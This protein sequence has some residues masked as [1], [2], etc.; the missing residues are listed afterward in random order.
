MKR[1]TNLFAYVG[2]LLLAACLVSAIVIPHAAPASTVPCVPVGSSANVHV[3]QSPIIQG[4]INGQW[5][6]LVTV[7]GGTAE[8]TSAYAFT[9]TIAWGFP[10]DFFLGKIDAI[11]TADAANYPNAGGPDGL[12]FR[13]THGKLWAVNKISHTQWTRFVVRQLGLQWGSN[14]P[15]LIVEKTA[16][17]DCGPDRRMCS[18]AILW[19]KA[20]EA[21]SLV[22]P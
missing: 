16:R 8:T 18:D 21:L 2:G 6:G 10:Y 17:F 13:F 4:V 5:I 15:S 11:A 1:R 20:A 14:G 19:T 3:C 22:Q 12:R 9:A 7:G